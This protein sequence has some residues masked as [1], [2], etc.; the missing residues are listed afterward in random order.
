MCR[1]FPIY[2]AADFIDYITINIQKTLAQNKKFF[3]KRP[4]V[5]LI[6]RVTMSRSFALPHRVQK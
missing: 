1:K 5:I 3:P 4:P 2:F 6:N